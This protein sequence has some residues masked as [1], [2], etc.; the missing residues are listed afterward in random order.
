MENVELEDLDQLVNSAGWRR[1][2][3]MVEKQYGRGS[4]RFFD[5]VTQAAKGDNPHANDHLRQIIAEQ[6][7]ALEAVSLVT[8]RLKT[9]QQPQQPA[10]VGGSR[11]GGL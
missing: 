4:D 6:R 2:A 7:G 9:L 5:A 1:Y 10:L 11:R 8:Q 3:E